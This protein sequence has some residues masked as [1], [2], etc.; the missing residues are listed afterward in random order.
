MK[1]LLEQAP[2]QCTSSKLLDLTISCSCH[3]KDTVKQQANTE[4]KV[5]LNEDGYEGGEEE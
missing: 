5:E 3:K 1:E 2:R 4:P